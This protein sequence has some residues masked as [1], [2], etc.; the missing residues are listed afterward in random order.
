MTRDGS[1]ENNRE[2]TDR[3]VELRLLFLPETPGGVVADSLTLSSISVDGTRIVF[4]GGELDLETAPKLAARLAEID[5]VDV[6]LDLWDLAFIDSTGIQ[7]IVEEHK[8]LDAQGRRLTVR[9]VHGT[10]FR[11][12]ELLKLD[13][14]LHV[15]SSGDLRPGGNRHAPAF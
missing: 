1:G 13:T 5:G 8:R 15:S 2:T 7:V 12:L 3:F 11:V 14:V 6:V 9:W 4:V 10:P